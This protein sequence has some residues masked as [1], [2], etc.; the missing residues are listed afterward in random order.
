MYGSRGLRIQDIG[1]KGFAIE[2][3]GLRVHCLRL[4]GTLRIKGV[5]KLGCLVCQTRRHLSWSVLF[6]QGRH[7]RTCSLSLY[8]YSLGFAFVLSNDVLRRLV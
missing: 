1:F 3:L 7:A 6:H 8:D 4:K 2:I 5:I